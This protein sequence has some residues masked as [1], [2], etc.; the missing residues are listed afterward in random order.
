MI[1]VDSTLLR[2]C[3]S[4]RDPASYH[5][6]YMASP[7][8]AVSLPVFRGLYTSL[9][10]SLSAEAIQ[11]V[12]RAIWFKMSGRAD[13]GRAIFD[14]EL[15]AYRNFPVV[16]IEHADLEFET[17]RWGAAWKILDTKLRELKEA[18]VDLDLPEHRL[19][20]LMWAMLGT[21]HRGDL[22]SA[23][24]EIERTQVWLRG[25]PVANYTDVQVWLVFLRRSC[26]IDNSCVGKLHPKIRG[27]LFVHQVEFELS[28]SRHRTHTNAYGGHR[29]VGTRGTLGWTRPTPPVF[30]YARHV[31]RGQFIFPR[32]TQSYTPGTP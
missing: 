13:D 18:N 22:S 20:A 25:V 5:L 8:I 12:E 23:I 32:G 16:I 7:N 10:R 9:Y 17:G 28:K 26:S 30:D 21:R 3:I 1:I 31:L 24:H 4:F 14:H 29:V 15:K 6:L 19:M 11:D 2:E 27:N